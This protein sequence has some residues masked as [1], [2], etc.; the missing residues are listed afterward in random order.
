MARKGSS[1]DFQLSVPI[2]LARKP[3]AEHA[4]AS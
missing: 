4:S 2:G 1:F 3:D